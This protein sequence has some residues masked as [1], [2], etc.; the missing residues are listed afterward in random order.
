MLG[1][2]VM[3]ALWGWR[4]VLA[5]D[6]T[7]LPGIVWICL[8]YA[9]VAATGATFIL[10]QFASL[11][12]PSAKVMAYTYLVPGWVILWQMAL[13][14]PHPPAIVMGGVALTLLALMQLLKDEAAPAR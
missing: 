3:V 13:G 4:D 11:R 7:T 5:T 9:A 1:G 12:L 6:W 10:L 14:Q 2:A 8:I